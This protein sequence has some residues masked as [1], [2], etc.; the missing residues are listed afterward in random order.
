V[1]RSTMTEDGVPPL[2]GLVKNE[3]SAAPGR[4]SGYKARWSS[5]A[6]RVG[7]RRVDWVRVLVD[8]DQVFVRA[9]VVGVGFRLPVTRPISQSL[10]EDL[11]ESRTPHV[12]RYL[13]AGA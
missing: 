1:S 2:S 8:R 10:A 9:E 13:D 6:E 4:P 3:L 5:A 12:T 11:I 7:L